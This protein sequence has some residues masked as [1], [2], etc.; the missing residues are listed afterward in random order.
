MK[1]DVINNT[2]KSILEKYGGSEHLKSNNT[3][4]QAESYVEFAPDGRVVKGLDIVIPKSKYIE[5]QLDG[6][7]TK[8]WGSFWKE[9]QWGYGCC[10]NTIKNSYCLGNGNK[11]DKDKSNK[12]KI[13]AV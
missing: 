12:R 5:D 10:Q 9:G 11:D 4:A 2:K 6:N 1:E 7:H 8:I 13:D 3:V